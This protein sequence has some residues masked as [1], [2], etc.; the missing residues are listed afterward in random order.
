MCI[1][2]SFQGEHTDMSPDAIDRIE[3]AHATLINDDSFGCGRSI[4][5]LNLGKR[6][7]NI[8]ALRRGDIE[9]ESPEENTILQNQDTLIIRGKPRGVEGADRYIQEG[10]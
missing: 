10:I 2:D 9:C 3:F 1:R 7:V 5:S 8:I 4:E 6:K